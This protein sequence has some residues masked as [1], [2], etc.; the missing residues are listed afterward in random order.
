MSGG[1]RAAAINFFFFFRGERTLFFCS[2]GRDSH[3][4]VVF[5]RFELQNIDEVWWH[6]LQYVVWSKSMTYIT[7]MTVPFFF[8]VERS[9]ESTLWFLFVPRKYFKISGISIVFIQMD[10][11]RR[12]RGD[13]P[14]NLYKILETFCD[15]Y[16][17]EAGFGL[18]EVEWKVTLSLALVV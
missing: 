2:F 5:E 11:G 7:G 4:F 14:I 17:W 10:R 6:P 18:K 3:F 16:W 9:C 1:G 15:Y 8:C 13:D 12:K